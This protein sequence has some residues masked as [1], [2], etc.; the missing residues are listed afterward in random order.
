MKK[1]SLI[2]LSI[3][4]SLSI[5]NQSALANEIN[6]NKNA[7][8][9]LQMASYKVKGK[10]YLGEYIDYNRPLKTV[11]GNSGVT[12]NLSLEKSISASASTTF[13]VG[14]SAV[15]AALGFSIN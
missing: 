13:G 6:N 2:L 12:L 5:F 7:K 8:I 1:I 4:L 10:K 11:S 3:I 15:S 14:G 9:T